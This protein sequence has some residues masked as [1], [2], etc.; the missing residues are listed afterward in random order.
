M[1]KL[2]GKNTGLIRERLIAFTILLVF[3]AILCLIWFRF[4]LDP[5]FA[6]PA[7]IAS[8]VLLFSSYAVTLYFG[9]F[10]LPPVDNDIKVHNQSGATM[11]PVAY[12]TAQDQYS[13]VV[14][15]PLTDHT[16]QM[17]QDKSVAPM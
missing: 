15:S 11:Q 1:P 13:T 2:Q 9:L 17:A 5:N 6:L 10:P 4:Y 7:F 8:L 14:Q 16:M 12:L 3:A